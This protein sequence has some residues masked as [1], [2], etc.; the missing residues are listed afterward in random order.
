M[1]RLK[2]VT[3]KYMQWIDYMF[4]NRPK[5][6]GVEHPGNKAAGEGRI[7]FSQPR[8]LT[9]EQYA[10]LVEARA[11]ARGVDPYALIKEEN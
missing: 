1:V 4:K 11:K 3:H 7:A 5:V 10:E 8:L 2:G 6:W 9:Q